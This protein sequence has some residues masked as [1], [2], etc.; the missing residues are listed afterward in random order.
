MANKCVSV[1][2]II[3]VLVVV[4]VMHA[5]AILAM[6]TLMGDDRLQKL[7][8]LARCGLAR[9]RTG[10]LRAGSNLTLASGYALRPLKSLL[11]LL[12]AGRR[13]K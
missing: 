5:I 12:I 1:D 11:K 13:E 2:E 4:C 10:L 6:L 3:D 9:T 8:C 7:A